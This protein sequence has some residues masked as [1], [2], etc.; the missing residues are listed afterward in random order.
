[1]LCCRKDIVNFNIADQHATV[2]GKNAYNVRIRKFL[3]YLAEE[4]LIDNNQLSKAL[5]SKSARSKHIISILDE[6]EI[7]MIKQPA[8]INNKL[9]LRDKAMVCLGLFE[10]LRASDIV[11]LKFSD[12]DW[13]NRTISIIQKKTA[14]AVVLPLVSEAGNALYRYIRYARPDYDKDDHIFIGFKAPHAISGRG[15]CICAINRILPDRKNN[16]TG[17]H[18]LRKT[19]ASRLLY[20]GSDI[21]GVSEALGHTGNSTV[22]EYLSLDEKRIRMCSLSL[23]ETGLELPEDIF[24]C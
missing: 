4:K 19:Y 7:K 2:E 1:M 23:R 8:D 16:R 3:D 17:F 10:G 18:I 13:K 11:G 15:T 21:S 5:F 9:E 6:E 14:K 24:R 12:I 22:H 20:G